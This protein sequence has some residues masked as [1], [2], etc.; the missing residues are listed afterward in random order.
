MP[1]F[2]SMAP[3]ISKLHTTEVAS[4]FRCVATE[5]GTLSDGFFES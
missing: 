5:I 4:D 2:S 1:C 3:T